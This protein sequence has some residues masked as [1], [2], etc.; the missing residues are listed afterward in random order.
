M[1]TQ[2]ELIGIAAWT[3]PVL[4]Q[5]ISGKSFQQAMTFRRNIQQAVTEYS[6]HNTRLDM[7]QTNA[8][9]ICGWIE[10]WCRDAFY[11]N[12]LRDILR[13]RQDLVFKPKSAAKSVIR[14][15][16]AALAARWNF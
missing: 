12:R 2:S 15:E 11:K 6:R 13:E 9:Q 5:K 16:W 3:K 10:S 4:H 7:V 14:S 1:V 8:I